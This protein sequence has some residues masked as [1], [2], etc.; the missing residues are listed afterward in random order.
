MGPI[1]TQYP[2]PQTWLGP[3]LK[4]P[5]GLGPLGPL[6]QARSEGMDIGAML[7]PFRVPCLDPIRVPF[8]SHLESTFLVLVLKNYG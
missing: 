8:G 6:A 4:G 3:N 1:G 2:Y 5:K 7:D